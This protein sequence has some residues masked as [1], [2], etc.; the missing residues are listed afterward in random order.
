MNLDIRSAHFIEF[1]L[2]FSNNARKELCCN[3]LLKLKFHICDFTELFLSTFSK[4]S[5]VFYGPAGQRLWVELFGESPRGKGHGSQAVTAASR[6]LHRGWEVSRQ[7]RSLL[8]DRSH[9]TLGQGSIFFI[10]PCSQHKGTSFHQFVI[11]FSGGFR[12]ASG[13]SGP[14]GAKVQSIV[15][16]PESHCKTWDETS[17]EAKDVRLPQR[18]CRENHNSQNCTS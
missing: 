3:L 8:R 9:H 11:L 18:L 15:G 17:V 10:H 12:P 4:C 2:N 1:I 14:D 7:L 5:C 16:L 13:Q 6:L